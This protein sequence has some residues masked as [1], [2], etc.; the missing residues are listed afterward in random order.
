MSPTISPTVSPTDQPDEED[1]E[2]EDAVDDAVEDEPPIRRRDPSSWDPCP[3]R[4]QERGVSNN[5][6]ARGDG[7]DVS[8]SVRVLFVKQQTK[9][10][11]R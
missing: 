4:Q 9:G 2:E 5:D 1:D 3:H 8:Q 7:V 10:L 11:I 6:T